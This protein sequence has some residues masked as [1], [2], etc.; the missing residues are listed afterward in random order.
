M[1]G[2]DVDYFDQINQEEKEQADRLGELLCWLYRPSSVIDIGCAT[3]LYLKPFLELG[4]KITGID[5]SISVLSPEVLLIPRKYLEISDITKESPK[6]KSDLAMSIEVLEHIDKKFARIAIDYISK[7]SDI[8][9]FTAAQ[10][11]Q[12]GVG[13]VNC[14]PK[15]YWE[16]FFSDNGFKRDVKDEFYLRIIMASGYHMGWLTNNLMIFKKVD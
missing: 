11:G 12:G 14:Q 8:I 1:P 4:V 7:A 15:G 13:H 10:P 3:G 16:G 5:N 6:E 2:Y 9:F